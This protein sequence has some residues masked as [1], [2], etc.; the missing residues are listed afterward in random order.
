MAATEHYDAVIIGGGPAGSSTAQGLTDAGMRVLVLDKSPFPRDKVCAGWITPEVVMLAEL[1]LEE[2][3]QGRTLQPIRRF[4]TGMLGEEMLTTDY[5]DT[6]SYGIR[7]S[8]FDHYLLQRSG[9][10]LR[11]GEPLAEARR[12]N[13]DWLIND[14]IRTPL[15]IGA[16]GHACPVAR[17]LNPQSK[18]RGE[19]VV[20]QEVEF[21]LNPVQSERCQVRHDTPELYF[22]PELDGYG[23]CFRKGNYLNIGL[24]RTHNQQLGAYVEWFRRFLIEKGRVPEDIPE[25]FH[26]H[27]YRLA[28]GHSARKVVGDGVMLVGDAVGLA[29]PHS[30]EGIRTAVE[31]GM[32][33]AEAAIDANGDY[34]L[35]SINA[36]A[37]DLD[38]YYRDRGETSLPIPQALRNF[39]AHLLLSNRY[40]TRHVLL[41][42]WFLHPD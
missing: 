41:D 27:A 18:H 17:M 23:W 13:G 6:V 1:D 40:L 19:V 33:A 28:T 34:R 11:L 7:R 3:R 14:T 9:A 37:K 26:G 12:N 20:A 39:F 5:G 24:G 32:L 22:L 2:Y 38:A 16:G 4:R 25:N 10:E 8:E 30:G 36:Y 35:D 21:P 42:N 15:L 29:Y 31:S